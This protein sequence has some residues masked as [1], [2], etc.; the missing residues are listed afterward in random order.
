MNFSLAPEENL[1][2]PRACLKSLQ[3][4]EVWQKALEKEH[5]A[6]VKEK[7]LFGHLFCS[8]LLPEK[9]LGL[10]T[11]LY[12]INCGSHRNRHSVSNSFLNVYFDF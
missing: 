3:N 8:E 9:F 7:S 2:P 10:N 4:R 5:T 12:S 11:F 6:Q 1:E